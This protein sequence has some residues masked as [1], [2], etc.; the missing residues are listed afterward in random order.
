[1]PLRTIRSVVHPHPDKLEKL[2]RYVIEACKQ[3][4]RNTLLQVEP[5]AEWQAYCRSRN[6]PSCRILAHPE[7]GVFRAIGEDA[8]LAVGPE[9]GFREEEITWALEAG[10]KIVGLGERILRV[11]TAAL[12]LAT[13]ATFSSPASGGP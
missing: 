11:E 1:V 5:M 4:G 8:V 2:K 12:V 6:L 13:L 9:G 10:W 7:G 3:C